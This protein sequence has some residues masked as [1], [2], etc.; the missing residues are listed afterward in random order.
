VNVH[1]ISDIRQIDI[2]TAEPL[3]PELSPSEIEIAIA[4]SKEY[5]LSGIGQ[6]P[7]ELIQAGGK[8]LHFE[9]HK[10]NS[11]WN[12]EEFPARWKESVWIPCFFPS[13]LICSKNLAVP[14]PY[15]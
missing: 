1:R 13:I 5:K 11:N 10:L 2:P 9:I 12:K 15:C 6:I 14:H 4:K 7:A 3:V 8:R